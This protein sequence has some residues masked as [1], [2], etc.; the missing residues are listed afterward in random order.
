[1]P[2]RRSRRLA[3]L[4][5]LALLGAAPA[6]AQ[7]RGEMRCGWLH[8]PTPGNWWLVDRDGQWV[9]RSQGEAE[10]PGMELIPDLTGPEWVRTGGGSYGYGCVCLRLVADPK[11]RTVQQILSARQQ[12]LS[13]C[14][15]D[16]H[17]PPP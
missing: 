8:N 12:A 4:A 17:L 6:F 7:P 14:R 9:L 1:M 11:T 10:L 13:V 16:R 5:A 15:K 3:L 2:A